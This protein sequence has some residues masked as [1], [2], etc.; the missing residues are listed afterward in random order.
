MLKALV[1]QI[2]LT[3]AAESS[4]AG[5]VFQ[6][7][8]GNLWATNYVA[9][10]F[11]DDPFNLS[12]L[13]NGEKI[14]LNITGGYETTTVPNLDQTAVPLPGSLMLLSSALGCLGL[15]YRRRRKAV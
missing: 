2:L 10:N 5:L 3:F 14:P 1:L 7:N 8:F 13:T 11:L 9:F 15:I 6:I 4:S 12:T